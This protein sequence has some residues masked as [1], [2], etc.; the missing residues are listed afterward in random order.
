[1]AVPPLNPHVAIVDSEG[2]PTPAFLQWWQQ[3]R[4][5][6]DEIT[7]LGTSTEVGAVLDKIGAVQ[8]DVLYRGPSNWNVLAP[9]TTGRF[10][11]TNGAGVD[12]E[13]GV[14]AGTFLAL[15]DTPGSYAGQAGRGVRV[16]LAEN[17]LEYTRV[18]TSVTKVLLLS[19]D[20]Q[21]GVDAVLLSGDAQSGVDVIQLSGV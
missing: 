12:P 14:A 11:K 21:S 8:G 19:G 9:G 3:Q 4:T 10:L 13:W 7:P 1:V 20:A 18:I 15:L 17:A 16:N 5:T 6:N 2:R